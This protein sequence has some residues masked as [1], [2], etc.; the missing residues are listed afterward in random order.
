MSSEPSSERKRISVDQVRPGMYVVGLDQPWLETP[1]LCHQRLIKNQDDIE[2]LKR[3]G[4]REVV[5]D[6]ARGADVAPAPAADRAPS[7]TDGAGLSADSAR[8]AGKSSSAAENAFEA[9]ARELDACQLIQQ[10][11]LAAAE[12]IFDGAMTGAP[13]SAQVAEKVV[14]DLLETIARSPEANLLLVQMRRFKEDLAMHGINVCVLS[15]VVNAVEAIAADAVALGLGALLH[16]VGETRL[17]RN[18]LHKMAGLTPTEERLI[19]RHPALGEQLL[20]QCRDLPPEARR[21]VV[22]HH[23]RLDG[24]G[25]PR[26]ARAGD[27]SPLSQIVALADLYDAMLSG[28]RRSVLQPID[29]LRQLFVLGQSGAFERNLVEHVIRSLGV[30]PVGT[31]VQLN[32]GERGIVVAA[33][34]RDTLKPTLRI[35]TSRLGGVLRHGPIVSLAE[36]GEE[37]RIVGA[38]N[39]IKEGINP[40]AFLKPAPE[41]AEV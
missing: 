36:S 32:T 34:H 22:E 28:R 7:Q 4:I 37:R 12:S 25:Y 40:L 1:F 6:P 19:E 29:A 2:V 23:E 20:A 10:Q 16:D 33:N 27:I 39:P 21:I 8:G 11:A 26:H 9:F 18:L 15:L 38:L 5:I 3:R 24:S 41:K 14:V 17:P 13:V 31:L 35:I 30:Y